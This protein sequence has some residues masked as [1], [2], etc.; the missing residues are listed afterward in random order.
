M[1]QRRAL[2]LSLLARARCNVDSSAAENAVG[3]A[4]NASYV[5]E[6]GPVGAE[7]RA[8]SKVWAFTKRG[9]PGSLLTTAS[10]AVGTIRGA[11]LAHQR[12]LPPVEM[13]NQPHGYHIPVSYRTRILKVR[14]VISAGGGGNETR[15]TSARV[16]SSSDAEPELRAMCADV[17]LPCLLI[18][19][20]R[21][22]IPC[23]RFNRAL[24]GYCLFRFKM[25]QT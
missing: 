13:P 4:A 21:K 19:K 2:M 12:Q 18:V 17:T 5:G 6:N 10:Q 7:W 11:P 24:D 9:S 8:A 20:T 1:L 23:S 22:A 15:C 14:L 25:P 3:A 16:S